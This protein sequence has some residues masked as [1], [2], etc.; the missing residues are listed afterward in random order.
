MRGEAWSDREGQGK[1][2]PEVSS[3]SAR[4]GMARLGSAL[5]SAL[6]GLARLGSRLIST[7]L[8]SGRL[9]ARLGSHRLSGWIGLARLGSI[10]GFWLGSARHFLG[11]PGRWFCEGLLTKPM[12][13]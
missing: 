13:K 7:R 1:E 2:Q 4:F 6:L 11:G 8:V 12:Q 9:S 3:G 10:I 5:G